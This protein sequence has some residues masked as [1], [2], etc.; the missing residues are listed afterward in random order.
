MLIVEGKSDAAFFRALDCYVADLTT[1]RARFSR[2]Y[3]QLHRALEIVTI[4]GNA[5]R[6][7]VFESLFKCLAWHAMGKPWLA[8]TP[9]SFTVP[10]DDRLAQCP[11]PAREP[12]RLPIWCTS[13]FVGLPAPTWVCS[14]SASAGGLPP[15]PAGQDVGLV[16]SEPPRITVRVSAGNRQLLADLLTALLRFL[17][18]LSDMVRLF[19][20]AIEAAYLICLIVRSGLRHHP[21]TVCS[22]RLPD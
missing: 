8:D 17:D 15:A 20:R 12:D 19:D 1:E 13:T 14:G 6:A 2:A 5:M 7:I 21:L 11:L 10:A 18:F 9:A 3:E 4:D 22:G 16:R